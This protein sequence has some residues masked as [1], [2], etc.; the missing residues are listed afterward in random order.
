[1][2]R[3]D[4]RNTMFARMGWEKDGEAYQDFY[5]RNPHLKEKD[6]YMRTLPH[7]CGEGTMSYH[8]VHSRLADSVFRFL[9]DINHLAEGPVQSPGDVDVDPEVMTKRLKK[10]AKYYGA[11]DVGIAK[12]Q[13]HFWYS[14]RGRKEETYG[15][16]I[17][18]RHEYAIVFAVEMDEDMIDR[19]PQVEEVIEV[20]KGY[21]NAGIIGMVLS[22]FLR[23]IGFEARNHMDGNYLVV[24]PL[25]AQE[26]G[27]GQ[28]GRMGILNT[29]KFGPRVRLGVITTNLQLVA[30]EPDDFGFTD[31]CAM[32]GMCIKTCP[33]KAIPA[34]AAFEQDGAKRWQIVQ[35]NCYERWR[36]LGTDC[37]VCLSVCPFSHHVDPQLVAA[38]KG[39]KEV[40]AEI[41]KQ[42]RE[43]YGK[44]RYIRTPLH[45]IAD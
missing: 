8:P 4:E 17:E 7:I 31:F 23:E 22:Y 19:A 12:M 25:V 16:P 34:T 20:T 28:L 1:M 13:D 9:G 40:M 32:C 5:E 18:G 36:S 42:H 45:L 35:E 43:T 44:R 29:R 33:G 3:I 2:K 26:A 38:M 6:D 37:G 21:L 24:A 15:D 14:H 10:L 30:D 41:L 27:L 11:A 39:N